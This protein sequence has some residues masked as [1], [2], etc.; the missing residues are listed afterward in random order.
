MCSTYLSSFATCATDLPTL[1]GFGLLGAL[2]YFG[3][4]SIGAIEKDEMR[5]IDFARWSLVRRMNARAILSY[6]GDRRVRRWN[7]CCRRCCRI[8]IYR[9][10]CCAAAT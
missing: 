7:G 5:A 2:T 3:L 1:A 6:C 4:D 9:A 10:R 8:L